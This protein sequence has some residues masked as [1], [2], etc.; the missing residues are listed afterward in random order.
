MR[1]LVELMEHV[2]YRL[3]GVKSL[4]C[5]VELKLNMQMGVLAL[6]MDLGGV[7]TYIHPDMNRLKL[8]RIPKILSRYPH[9]FE[10]NNMNFV[11]YR[12]SILPDGQVNGIDCRVVRMDAID[13]RNDIR[14]RD[15]W[16][17]K[18]DHT[19]PR[20]IF[21]YPDGDVTA[22]VKYRAEK[23]WLVFDR[24]QSCLSFPV[25]NLTAQIDAECGEYKVTE[26]NPPAD[27]KSAPQPEPP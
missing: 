11:S 27:V 10:W 22:E 1:A 8:T 2:A 20:Q 9:L 17:S 5:P 4:E 14:Q 15:I 25:F 21:R 16:I 7:Y 6:P 12:Y 26:E 18:K 23:R 3:K 24:I 19:T 13:P